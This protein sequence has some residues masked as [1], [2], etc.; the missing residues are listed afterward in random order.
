MQG[1]Y[2]TGYGHRWYRDYGYL[3][4]D[5]FRD[6]FVEIRHMIPETEYMPA[7]LLL[8]EDFHEEQEE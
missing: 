5:F 4:G 7:V 3:T 8:A 6:L 2:G 1:S